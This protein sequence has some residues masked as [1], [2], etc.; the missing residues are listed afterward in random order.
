VAWEPGDVIVV[1]EHWQGRLW[2]SRPVRVVVDAGDELV[3]WCP[4]GTVRLSPAGTGS[5]TFADL[6]TRGAWEL[7]EHVWDVSSLMLFR[8]GAWEATWVSFRDGAHLGWYVNLQEP[9]RRTERGL[10]TFD[11]ALDVVVEPDLTWA[12][13]DEDD[14][15]ALAPLLPAATV[16]AV[17][18]EADAA[19]GRIEAG[20][21]P[22]DETWLDWRPPS[23]WELPELPPD[24]LPAR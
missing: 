15:A 5:E 7:R 10:E 23:D 3:L 18:A 19:I 12:W 24:R 22:F 14:F 11:L 17:R 1:D 2:A 13:K 9:F 4:E 20:A 6:L 16:A 8:E 21:P